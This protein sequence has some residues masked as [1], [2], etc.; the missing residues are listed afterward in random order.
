MD[1][2]V[3]EYLYYSTK[4]RAVIDAIKQCQESKCT[5]G[6]V[7]CKETCVKEEGVKRFEQLKEQVTA[8]IEVS[9]REI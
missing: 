5:D 7:K 4:S 3:L 1:T 2:C 8:M 6:S 9:K